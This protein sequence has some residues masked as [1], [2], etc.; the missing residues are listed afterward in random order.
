MVLKRK[1]KLQTLRSKCSL[2][3][4]IA[5]VEVKR[6]EFGRNILEGGSVESQAIPDIPNLVCL[7]DMLNAACCMLH[8]LQINQ[9]VDVAPR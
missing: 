7:A 8:S 2:Y 5:K 3:H 4:S 1:R 9:V 6:E